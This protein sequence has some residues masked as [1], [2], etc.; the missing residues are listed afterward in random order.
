MIR[1]SQLCEHVSGVGHAPARGALC[2]PDF[3]AIFGALKELERTYPGFGEWYFGK[4]VPGVYAGERLLLA[5]VSGATISGVAIAKRGTEQKLCT[6]WV[7]PDARLSRVGTEL[8]EEAFEWM[9]NS[10]PL[11]TVPEERLHEFKGLLRRWS[12]G[13]GLSVCGYYGQGRVEHVFN[14]TLLPTMCS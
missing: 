7:H 8:A 11:F 4:V 3:D 1:S 14:G 5:H 9:G 6:L 2:R 12:F 13:P 10:K